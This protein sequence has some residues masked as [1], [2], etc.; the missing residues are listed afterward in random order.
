MLHKWP[1]WLTMHVRLFLLTTFVYKE[2]KCPDIC[3]R[4]KNTDLAY[5]QQKFMINVDNKY[6]LR[7][8]GKF[9]V[10]FART[11]LKSNC[12]SIY[13]VK[14]YNSLSKS[15]IE[16]KNVFIPRETRGYRF[17][18]FR[19]SV[20]PSVRLRVQAISPKVFNGFFFKF[21]IRIEHQ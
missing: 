4:I 5:I 17:Q 14:L 20:R 21:H 6:C 15:I 9:K 19:L 8:K 3:I 10:K 16:A 11:T 12:I 1:I 18:L 7:S 13:G 2:T